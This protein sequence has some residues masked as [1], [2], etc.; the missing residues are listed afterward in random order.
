[1]KKFSIGKN[2]VE[3]F[4]LISHKTYLL[5]PF[6]IWG[7]VEAF[8]LEILYFSP[9]AFLWRVGTPIISKFFGEAYTRY[10]MFLLILPKLFHYFQVVIF[11]FLGI[12]LSAMSV[13]LLRRTKDKLKMDLRAVIN[14]VRKR[15]LAF[16]VYG[17]II[18]VVGAFVKKVDT[19][20]FNNILRLVYRSLP[21]VALKAIPFAR[22]VS[23]LGAHIF[24]NVF[25]ILTIP[26]LVMQN[27][28][29]VRALSK[30]VYLG[31]RH[32][33]TIFVT[34][35]IPYLVYL[36]F[37]LLKSFPTEVATKTFPEITFVI[38]FA[39]IFVGQLVECFV[40]ICVSRFLIYK[41]STERA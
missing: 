39:G 30:S 37:V 13:D 11:I 20:L 21:D 1:V 8:T 12:F 19:V 10:P 28:S 25:L 14:Y 7:L 35:L 40:I 24:M 41:M 34:I 4:E 5:I 3:T 9:G 18:V 15:Y 29:F 17:I 16:V 2:W 31:F 38:T 22:S 33:F 27:V 23:L 6:L 32:F 26:V 36:P